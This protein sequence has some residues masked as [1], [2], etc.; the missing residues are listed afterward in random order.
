MADY[1]QNPLQAFGVG[2]TNVYKTQ[3]N[4]LIAADQTDFRVIEIESDK[5]WHTERISWDGFKDLHFTEEFVTGS[6]FEPTSD[7]ETEWKPFSFNFRT[8][9][10]VG[11][12]YQF[13]DTTKP[14]W[15]IW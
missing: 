15:K 5:V 1:E 2:F 14:W 12:T 3:D 11:G 4:F 9:E 7:D 8:K 6:A 10:I 13:R